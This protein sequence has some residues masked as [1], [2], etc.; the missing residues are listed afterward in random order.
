MHR[1]LLRL[2]SIMKSLK[3]MSNPLLVQMISLKRSL[4]KSF[5]MSAKCQLKFNRYGKELGVVTGSM[6]LC[7]LSI[8][9]FTRLSLFIVVNVYRLVVKSWIYGVVHPIFYFFGHELN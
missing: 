1:G 2:W 9:Q 3:M 4:I 8:L 6:L 7:A 5:M